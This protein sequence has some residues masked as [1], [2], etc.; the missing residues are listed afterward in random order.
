VL[1][2]AVPVLAQV[3]KGGKNDGA[4]TD[5]LWALSYKSDGDDERIQS[6]INGDGILEA[7]IDMLGDN[8][9]N[10]TP[11]LR[12]IGNIVSGNDEQ[13]QAAVDAGLMT[14]MKGLLT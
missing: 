6:V 12:T 7:L 4:I 10:V 13:T 8:S 11:A 14:K 5:A 2:P 3:L 1:A 9:G